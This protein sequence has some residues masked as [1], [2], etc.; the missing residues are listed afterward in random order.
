MPEKKYYSFEEILNEK[1]YIVYTNVGYSML[2]L[3][4]QRKDIIEIHRKSGKCK[5]YD[6]VFYKRGNK[7]ILHRILK[8]LPEGYLIAGDH[9]TKIERDVTDEMILGVM[10]KVIRNGKT[11][12]PDNMWYKMYVHLWC[13]V[14]PVRMM[15]LKIEFWIRRLLSGVKR[16]ILRLKRK[17]NDEKT[18]LRSE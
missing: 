12:L 6:A 15:I 14:Y 9:C 18:V 7:Y 11:I 16:M 1:G 2:P 17:D 8:V 5:K 4:R 3:L 10:T 13:D